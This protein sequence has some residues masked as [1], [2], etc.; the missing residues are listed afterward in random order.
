MLQNWL[1]YQMSEDS[2]DFNFQQ[3]GTTP[4]WYCVVQRFLDKSLP[5]RVA[6]GKRTLR[7]SSSTRDLLISHPVTYSCGG[8]VKESV[9]VSSLPTTLDDDLKKTVSHLR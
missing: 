3:D 5:Q 9:Y 4:H 1:L 6:S 8:F 7:F 2:E